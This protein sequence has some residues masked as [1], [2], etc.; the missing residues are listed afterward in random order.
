MRQ[1]NLLS[2]GKWV[3]I[4][5]EPPEF[6]LNRLPSRA[7]KQGE[8]VGVET[9][10]QVRSFRHILAFTKLARWFLILKLAYSF[11]LVS[12]SWSP[13]THG[14]AIIWNSF[15]KCI[16]LN[17]VVIYCRRRSRCCRCSC[18]HSHSYAIYKAQTKM[19]PQANLFKVDL[20]WETFVIRLQPKM[21]GGKK[22][23]N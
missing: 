18:P 9:L 5:G 16:S 10:P 2:R 13:S 11:L 20:E 21:K 12:L 22:W 8:L 14:Q 19:K 23:A 7:N 15:V 4:T 3:Q 6:I 17:C 1:W